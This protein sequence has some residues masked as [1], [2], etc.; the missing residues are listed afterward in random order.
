MNQ[1]DESKSSY[2]KYDEHVLRPAPILIT[3]RIGGMAN[4]TTNATQSKLLCLAPS[5][6]LK[7]SRNAV[8]GGAATPGAAKPV[9]LVSVLAGLVVAVL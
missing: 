9:L 1:S 2:T 5:T 3:A 8:T 4:S 7:G 6:V